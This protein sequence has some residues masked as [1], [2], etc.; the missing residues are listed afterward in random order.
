LYVT[1]NGLTIRKTKLV[2][3][4][5]EGVQIDYEND[6]KHITTLYGQ[7]AEFLNIRMRNGRPIYRCHSALKGNVTDF[8]IIDEM[9]SK[10][11]RT[12]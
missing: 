6:M 2:V 5:R 9:A 11:D 8:C 1:E 7:N 10:D 12:V 4:F 3:L